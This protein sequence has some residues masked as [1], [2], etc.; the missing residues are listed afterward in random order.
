[1]FEPIHVIRDSFAD[2]GPFQMR[3][4]PGHSAANIGKVTK[5]YGRNL[6]IAY[7][8]CFDKRFLRVKIMVD[9]KP[10]VKPAV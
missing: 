1:M 8:R 10:A 3:A 6:Y 5:F 9:A 7:D 4:P 2:Q